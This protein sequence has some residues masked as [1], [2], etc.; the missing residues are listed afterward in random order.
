M[1]EKRQSLEGFKFVLNEILIKLMHTHMRKRVENVIAGR[2]QVTLIVRE[3]CATE[4][5][6]NKSISEIFSLSLSLALSLV[7]QCRLNENDN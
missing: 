2:K 1:N 6:I 3:R 5:S 7:G 4:L